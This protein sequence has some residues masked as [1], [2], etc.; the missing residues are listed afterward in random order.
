MGEAGGTNTAVGLRSAGGGVLP[1]RTV[2]TGALAGL[3]AGGAAFAAAE[4]S[5]DSDSSKASRGTHHVLDRLAELPPDHAVFLALDAGGGRVGAVTGLR[6]LSRAIG[7]AGGSI[8]TGLALGV[9]YFQAAGL[10]GQAPRQLERMSSFSGDLLKEDRCGG[11]VLIQVGARTDREAQAGAQQLVDAVPHW[12]VRWRIGVFR[13]E[14]RMESGRALTRNRFGYTEGQ[15][16][17]AGADEAD[18]R[19]LVRPGDGEPGWAV[20]GSYQVVRHIRFAAEAWAKDSLEEQ[21]RVIGRHRDGRWLDGTPTGENPDFT[22]DPHGKLTP[23]DSHVRLANPRAHR[24]SAP[25]LVR[26]SYSYIAPATGSEAPDEGLMF[27][28]Y[29]RSL[30]DGF[31]A[32][33]RRLAAGALNTYVLTTGGGYYF[34]PPVGASWIRD[35]LG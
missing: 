7:T 1:R 23:L 11:D 21:D 34:V 8:E 14:N 24:N 22:A 2:V 28:C 6:N 26:R 29:Q 9:T 31:L 17:P 32:V 33:Q 5:G 4:V 18:A 19:A 16:N 12:T 20:G 15:G 13:A 25:P 27:T 30:S 10:T 3:V 35:L